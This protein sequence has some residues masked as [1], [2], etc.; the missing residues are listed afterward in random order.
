M[1][2][3]RRM[4]CGH[5]CL[6]GAILAAIM[7]FADENLSSNLEIWFLRVHRECFCTLGCETEQYQVN[8]FECEWIYVLHAS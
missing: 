1:R 8:N 2:K 4:E 6:S 5:R 7:T 3:R